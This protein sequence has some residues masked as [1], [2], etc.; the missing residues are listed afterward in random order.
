MEASAV[1]L[2]SAKHDKRTE[3]KVKSR[4]TERT[5][6]IIIPAL[7]ILASGIA[8]GQTLP[9]SVDEQWRSYGHD[10]GGMRFSPLKQIH[11]AN[12]QQLQ[13]A[14]TYQ[15]PEPPN[16]WLASFESTPLMVDDVLYFAT[17]T[18]SAIAVDAESGKEIWIF[19]PTK[20]EATRRPVPNRGLAYWEGE[21]SVTCTGGRQGRDRRIFYAALDARLFAL[22]PGTGRPCE[23]FGEHGAIDLRKGVA[24]GWPDATYD[25]TSPPAVYRDLVITGCELQEH[26]SKGPSGAVRAFDVRTGNLVWRFNTVPRPGE[27]GHETWEG[28][29]WKDRSGTNAW[30]PMSVDVERG[31]IF[32]PL[33]SPSYDFYGADRK[34]SDLFGDCL[35]ALDAGTGKLRWYFQTVHHDLWDYDPPAQP[36][37]VNVRRVGG[38]IPAVALVT[39]TG[40]VFV[41]DRLTG[42]PVFPIGERPVPQSQIPGEASWPTQPFPV[43]PPPLAR[44]AVTLDDITTVTPESRKYCLE[45]FAPMLPGKLF[46][47]WRLTLTLEMPGTLGGANWHGASFDPSSGFLFVNVSEL[48]SVGLLK[49]QPAGSS[50][51][52]EWGSPWGSYARFWDDKHY[53][54]QQPPWGTLNAVDLNTGNLAWKVPLGVVDELEAKGVPQTGIY[55]LGGSLATAGGL[56]FIAGTADHRFRAFDSQT[57]EEL[58]VTKLESNGHANP[59][60]YL[61]EKT[62]KQ[63]VVIAVSP[64]GR[65]NA[66]TSAPTVLA[67]YALFPKGQL[68]PAQVRLETQPRT[69]AEGPGSL[70]PLI[71]PPR[72]APSQPVPFSHKTHANAGIKC[73]DCHRP[74][75]D[76]EQL[77]IP[78]LAQCVRCHGTAAKTS[79]EIQKLAAMARDQQAVSWV[80]VYQLPGFVSFSHQQHGSARIDCETCHGAVAT[81]D[82]LREEK[83]ISMVSCTS[84]HKL[85]NAST[86]CGVCH[87]IGY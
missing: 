79:P 32:L 84:C 30:P 43:K 7:L 11:R 73:A 22:D 42:Q 48:G 1:G 65:F 27:T 2:K 53:P 62:K 63:F 10:A 76:G 78:D 4:C 71:T 37:L 61:G 35:V 72:A 75:E 81:E 26:P 23:G 82:V 39:K 56:V 80:R 12:V 87:N 64:G 83:D 60:T 77:S 29:G 17:Q 52:Y 31:M 20:D 16:S 24:D 41:F 49:A 46:D 59:I 25:L 38:E 36:V 18:G 19:N 8:R 13:R 28:G 67:A 58:W 70:P 57:G 66:D 6:G 51:A 14:W 15:V 47:P 85:R 34:G 45:H 3:L 44:T 68:S 54:C 69:I 21:S 86:N 50:E 33:G 74:S 5:P 40:F 9:G 55:S